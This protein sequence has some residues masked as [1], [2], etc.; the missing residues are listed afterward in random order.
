MKFL[1]SIGLI[2]GA[3]AVLVVAGLSAFVVVWAVVLGLYFYSRLSERAVF[4]A[5]W[6]WPQF[7]VTIGFG[8]SVPYVILL[9]AAGF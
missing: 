3:M 1:Q 8:L 4:Y 6:S 2:L 7:L 5:N 9:F